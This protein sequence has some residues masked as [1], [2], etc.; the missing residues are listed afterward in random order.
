[1]YILYTYVCIHVLMYIYEKNFLGI[2]LIE[3]ESDRD[4]SKKTVLAN[5]ETRYGLFQISSK[6]CSSQNKLQSCDTRSY[7][8]CE[9]KCD[10]KCKCIYCM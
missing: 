10:G 5:G 6:E 9:M 4:T 3:H 8:C 2:C 1:M 7:P